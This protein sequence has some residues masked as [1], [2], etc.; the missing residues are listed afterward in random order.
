MIASKRTPTLSSVKVDL[1][2]SPRVE[3]MN[4]IRS[5]NWVQ[6]D[7]GGEARMGMGRG[8]V[9]AGLYID[10]LRRIRLRADRLEALF[11]AFFTLAA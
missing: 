8:W 1:G 4:G 6:E 9:L 3:S 7:S 10:P 5:V 2:Q 11:A